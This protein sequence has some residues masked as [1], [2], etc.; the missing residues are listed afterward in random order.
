MRGDENN[1][2]QYKVL[3]WLSQKSSKQWLKAFQA[4]DFSIIQKSYDDL[5]SRI[6]HSQ[7]LQ[8][9]D[10][11]A[12]VF[13]IDQDILSYEL[14]KEHIEQLKKQGVYTLMVMA[15]D[16]ELDGVLMPSNWVLAMDTDINEIENMCVYLKHLLSIDQLNKTLTKVSGSYDEKVIN[17]N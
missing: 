6:E 14:V 13:F 9:P 8:N 15:Q 11:H 3:F 16:V 2:D 17:Y 5:I 1:N 7:E 10:C 12:E 4:H